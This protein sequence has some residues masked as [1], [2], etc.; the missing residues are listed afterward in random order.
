M[1]F[2]VL[3]D[4]GLGCHGW[5]ELPL[6]SQLLGGDRLLVRREVLCFLGNKNRVLG[7]FQ[8]VGELDVLGLARVGGLQDSV[9]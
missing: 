6:G 5:R 3:E 1:R 2:I 8:G 4:D 7:S 9:D